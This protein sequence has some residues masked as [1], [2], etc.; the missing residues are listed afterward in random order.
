MQLAQPCWQG[1]FVQDIHQPP[2]ADHFKISKK[3][4][5]VVSC[6]RK[7]KPA[8]V[9]RWRKTTTRFVNN[10]IAEAGALNPDSLR[11][12]PPARWR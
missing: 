4:M 3:L 1:L 11:S 6:K 9:I 10:L 5:T 8:P 2:L 12:N 7:T